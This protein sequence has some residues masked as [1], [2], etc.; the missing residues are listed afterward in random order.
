[1]PNA[2]TTQPGAS[3][4]TTGTPIPL[5]YGYVWATGKRHAYYQ[6]QDTGNHDLDYTRVGIW[7]L[8]HGEWDGCTELW[9]NDK[10]V[11]R[12]NIPANNWQGWSWVQA[13]DSNTQNIVF[14]FHPGTDATI[15]AGLTPAST[16]PDQGVDLLWKVFPPAIQPVAFNRV[17]YYA[18]MRKQPIAQQTNTHQ[19][20][21]TQWTDINPIGLWRALKC[22]LFDGNGNMAGYAFTTNPVWH[23]VDVR[24]RRKLMPEYNLSVANGP[25]DLSSA[26]RACFDWNKVYTSAQYCDEILANGRRRFVG[27]YAFTAKTSLQ[28]IEAQI[29]Q[30]CRGFYSSYGGKYAL[31]V[32][33]PRSSVF[34][35]TRD[36]ILPGS[37]EANDQQAHTSANRYVGQFR[38][39]LVPQCNEIASI[40]TSSNGRPELTTTEPHPCIAGDFIAVGGTE[41]TYDGEWMVYSVPDIINPGTP[42]EIDPTTMVLERKGSNYPASVGAG[43]GIGLLYS[44]FSNRT[45]LFRHKA[46]ELARGAVALGVPRQ[47]NGLKTTIDLAT[48]TYDQVSRVV[49]YERDRVLGV[50]TTGTDGK[51]DAPYVTPP[52][53]RLSTSM[54]A[55][56][57]SGNL[58]C[59]IE[60]GDRVTV[61]P[62]LSFPYA[63]EYE[64]LDPKVVR[65]PT[66][67]VS[68]SSG[69]LAQTPDAKSQEIDFALGPYNESIMYDESDTDQAGWPSVP[70]SDPG[71]DSN[72]TG[73]DL[74][75]GGNFV[76]FTDVADTSTP[77]QLP[78]SGY[79]P[80]NLLDWASAAGT[81][82]QFH[83]AHTIRQ[84]DASSTRQLSLIYSDAI[85][86]TWGG[87]IGY[88]ALTW[89]GTATVTTINGIKWV[90][91]TLLGGEII[92]FGQGILPDGYTL[93]DAD[94]PSGFTFDPNFAMAFIHDQAES[95]NIMF[96]AGAN[97][98]SGGVVHVDVSDDTG[99][100]WHGNASVLI[101]AY[102]NNM[103]TFTTETVSGANWAECVLSNGKKF[104]VGVSKDLANG[105][106]FG[107]P[108]AAGAATTLQAI[109]GSSYGQYES[110]SNHAQGIGGCYLDGSN[111]AVIFF[112]DGGSDT[113]YGKA[114]VFGL[115]CESGSSTP[116]LVT[117]SPLSVSIAQGA[118]QQFA[119]T[120]TFNANPNVTWTVDGIAGGNVTVG[121]IDSTGLYTSPNATGTHT[122]TA[123]SVGDPTASGDATV[124]V[125]G[126]GTGAGGGGWLINGT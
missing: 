28:A 76:F 62:T 36:N 26:V 89:I 108:S 111:N 20:D 105:A 93:T 43:G 10:L 87:A 40:T 15:G 48:S 51:L 47:H 115:Y 12:T 125:S 18:L 66:V 4:L 55:A 116:T 88:A 85:G 39:L 96:L 121:T 68:S 73:I 80:G 23:W 58:A 83:S 17:A 86:H 16:G 114:D 22:R 61:D 54:F 118:Q 1:M 67:G 27:N 117:V 124:S 29:A 90:V 59:G 74:D 19:D 34:T 79:P 103:G 30:V 98:D 3:S 13:L 77:F 106:A 122:I 41:T 102:Q 44:R 24:L 78:S 6:I 46:A 2:S 107:I 63:G 53:I 120:V 101:F 7:L 60:P 113:W 32:D 56:D 5:G 64:V 104:G 109:A 82:I 91:L 123:T 99:H 33:M 71:N 100:T 45:P 11:W 70:G 35:F 9:I 69:S 57:A 52:M 42:D 50:D 112:Q 21:P 25:D 81:N 72:F 92:A 38:D 49:R 84:C 65:P 94:M 75:G 37:F 14:N 126:A 95:P 119:A 97:V 110:G 8:G 31:N